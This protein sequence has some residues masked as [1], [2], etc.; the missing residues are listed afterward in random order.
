M[1]HGSDVFSQISFH[2]QANSHDALAQGNIFD[3]PLLFSESA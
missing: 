2:D 3:F 1:E